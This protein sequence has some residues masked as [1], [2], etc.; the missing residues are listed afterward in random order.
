MVRHRAQDVVGVMPSMQPHI[1]NVQ[2]QQSP[3][4][5]C[6]WPPQHDPCVDRSSQT[7]ANGDANEICTHRRQLNRLPHHH[8]VAPLVRLKS[9]LER[10]LLRHDR[11][12]LF[13]L[14]SASSTFQPLSRGEV[15]GICVAEREMHQGDRLT[16]T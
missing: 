16:V 13:R 3:G 11:L 6:Q 14:A 2:R 9:W 5:G 8:L 1:G 12:A 7:D 15:N 10:P 4:P